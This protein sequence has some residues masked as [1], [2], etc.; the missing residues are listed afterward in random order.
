MKFL[1]CVCVCVFFFWCKFICVSERWIEN[2]WVDVETVIHKE[3]D[4]FL[5][6]YI[7][8]YICNNNEKFPPF[9]LGISV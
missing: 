1:F 3:N 7:I 4:G 6:Y 2:M 8:L 5:I 9:C